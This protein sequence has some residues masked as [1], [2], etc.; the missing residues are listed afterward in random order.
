[1]F[2][3]F[4]VRKILLR[5]VTFIIILVSN[6]KYQYKVL[7]YYP[8]I[9]SSNLY[10]IYIKQLMDIW[11]HVLAPY[12]VGKFRKCCVPVIFS[13]NAIYITVPLAYLALWSS[14]TSFVFWNVKG[15]QWG[16]TLKLYITTVWVIQMIILFH[17]SYNNAWHE[18]N[19][20]YI[21][22]PTTVPIILWKR[23][24]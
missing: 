20:R 12:C 18:R 4:Q 15:K 23:C 7:K 10:S 13:A 3:Y 16:Q 19:K 1:M 6:T 11:F 9:F 21:H 24:A 5:L 22:H 2:C 8:V 17:F 14:Q